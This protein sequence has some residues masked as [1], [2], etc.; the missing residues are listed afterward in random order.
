MLFPAHNRA[1]GG[2]E[3]SPHGLL[4]PVQPGELC[5]RDLRPELASFELHRIHKI[6]S[7]HSG[8]STSKRARVID[9][10]VGLTWRPGRAI[11]VMR[12]MNS[13]AGTATPPARSILSGSLA[14]R[15][16]KRRNGRWRWRARSSSKRWTF[17]RTRRFFK[18]A[19]EGSVD[20]SFRYSGKRAYAC[21]SCVNRNGSPILSCS[22]TH[23]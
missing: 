2:A 21:S 4:P 18:A 9:L 17:R 8:S 3:E 5:E 12:F 7:N 23:S 19:R 13:T 20:T 14:T 16:T 1:T 10:R 15:Q 6:P 11:W 22:S